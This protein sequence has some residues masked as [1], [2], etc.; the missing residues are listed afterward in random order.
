PEHL[1]PVLHTL[2]QQADTTIAELSIPEEQRRP[3]TTA[4]LCA[5]S[6]HQGLTSATIAHVGD[7]RVY[8]LR[9]GQALQRLTKDHGYF[10]FA[11][12]HQK[13][14]EEEALRIE[15]AEQADDLSSD[16]QD[17]F[18]QRNKITCAIGWSDFTFIPVRSLLLHPGDR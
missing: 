7:S 11:V 12:R 1:T 9:E 6:T 3:A 2:L 5:L 15:Q 13:L 8:L 16:E 10:P 14:S 18:A 17:H 4:A